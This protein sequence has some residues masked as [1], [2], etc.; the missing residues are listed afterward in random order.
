MSGIA[1]PTYMQ[2]TALSVKWPVLTH[3]ITVQPGR[4]KNSSH[5]VIQIVENND[6]NNER[7]EHTM[8]IFYLPYIQ[9][10]KVPSYGLKIIENIAVSLIIITY[11]YII[12]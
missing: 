10:L 1:L 4:Q 11:L 5:N 8:C 3:T 2:S 12:L 7:M 9:Q 6:I